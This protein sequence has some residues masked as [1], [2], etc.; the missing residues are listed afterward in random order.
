MD[1]F[2]WQQGEFKV[3]KGGGQNIGFHTGH[4]FHISVYGPWQQGVFKVCKGGGQN[5]GF[6][7]GHGFHI[8]VYG[9]RSPSFS[10]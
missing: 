2:P 5:I 10:M 7:T 1:T 9:C 4:G 8:S 6:H 3:C